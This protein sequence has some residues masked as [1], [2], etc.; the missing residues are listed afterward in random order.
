[1]QSITIA[2]NK[3]VRRFMAI[4]PASLKNCF[5]EIFSKEL[6]YNKRFIVVELTITANS[7][8]LFAFIDNTALRF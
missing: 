6:L 1:M 8:A 7:N 5:I 2:R 4:T 3:R